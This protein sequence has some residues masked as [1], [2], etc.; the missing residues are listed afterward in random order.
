MP[1]LPADLKLLAVDLAGLLPASGALNRDELMYRAGWAACEAASAA[2]IATTSSRRRMAMAWLWPLTTAGLLL[3]SAALGI[4]LATREPELIVV[5]KV[6]TPESATGAKQKE[7]APVAPATLPVP[8]ERSAIV[9]RWSVGRAVVGR[10]PT[11]AH[12]D[13]LSLRDRVLAYGVDVLPSY[14]ATTSQN[15]A[16]ADGQSRYGTLIGQL[17]GG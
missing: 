16:R 14:A 11:P 6:T 3:L 4:A 2:V 7:P 12:S 17:L 10:S 1:E 15:D 8:D 9:S 5:T 13:Y